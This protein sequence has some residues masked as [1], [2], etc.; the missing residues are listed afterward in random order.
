[1]NRDAGAVRVQGAHNR[2]SD[3]PCSARDERNLCR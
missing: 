2:C 3:A 1:V